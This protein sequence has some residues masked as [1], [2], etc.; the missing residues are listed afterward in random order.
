[1]NDEEVRIIKEL[2]R[3]GEKNKKILAPHS[4][5]QVKYWEGYVDGLRELIR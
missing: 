3:S 5:L 2:I 4:K 1:M